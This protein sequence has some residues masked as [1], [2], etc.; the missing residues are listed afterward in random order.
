MKETAI[1]LLIRILIYDIYWYIIRIFVSLQQKFFAIQLEDGH[2]VLKYNLGSGTVVLRSPDTY[3]DGKWHSLEAT[4]GEDE[5]LLIVSKEN[6]K[7]VFLFT[8]ILMKKCV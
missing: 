3:N 1:V 6:Y 5:G 8:K 7:T 4:R 2:V